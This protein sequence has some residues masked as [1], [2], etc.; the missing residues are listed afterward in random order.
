MKSLTK[1]GLFLEA[2]LLLWAFRLALWVVPFRFLG[3]AVKSPSRRHGRFRPISELVQAVDR[4]TRVVPG[5][6]CLVRAM[7]GARLFARHGHDSAIRIGVAKRPSG[8]GAHAWL[9]ARGAIL[10]GG[11]VSGFTCLT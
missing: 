8:F 6:T 2:A 1:F 5:A 11:P 9:E 7:A 3:E 10:I 4:A